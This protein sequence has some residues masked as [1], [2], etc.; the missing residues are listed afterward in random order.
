V[1]VL[2]SKGGSSCGPV[3]VRR[4]RSSPSDSRP[5][6]A[7]RRSVCCAVRMG[8][9]RPPATA[10]A[11]SAVASPSP[12]PSGD[13]HSRRRTPGSNACWRSAPLKSMPGRWC[14][15]TRRDGSGAPGGGPVPGYSRALAAA[16]LGRAA[17]AAL[18]P[19]RPTTSRSPRAAG[20]PAPRLGPPA[21]PVGRATGVGVASTSWSARAHTARASAWDAGDTA[22][23]PGAVSASVGP[24]HPSAGAGDPSGPCLDR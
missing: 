19:G 21:S 4:H 13:G 3:G 5:S 12:M 23:P 1:R 11:R 20:C 22:R 10:G 16:R 14:G 6:G 24:P 7:S 15:P 9:R 17:V 18:A 2:S 8:F